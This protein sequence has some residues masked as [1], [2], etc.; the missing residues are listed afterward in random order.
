V[1]GDVASVRDGA[2]AGVYRNVARR[3]SDSRRDVPMLRSGIRLGAREIA[4]AA[5]AGLDRLNVARP[6]RIAVISTGNELV[7]P[8]RPIADHE[9][10]DS[11]AYALRAALAEH[12]VAEVDAEHVGDDEGLIQRSLRRHFAGCDMIVLA[13]GVSHGKL[14]LVRPALATAG[15]REII[16]QVAQRPGKPMWFGVGPERQAVFGLPGNP[17]AALM[18]LRRYVVPAIERAL[19]ASPQPRERIALA[20]PAPGARRLAHFV[21]VRLR[22]DDLGQV[23]AVPRVPHGSGDFLALAGTDGFV[24]LPPSA[25]ELPA[26]FVADLYRW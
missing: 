5:A 22:H 18:C 17:V 24:E 20:S 12:G 8:G 9:V 13:G 14:D 7:A 4:V 19:G 2:A 10:R 21:P 23:A 6:P 1:A 15:A 26:G 11:N 3:G 16:H 25:A